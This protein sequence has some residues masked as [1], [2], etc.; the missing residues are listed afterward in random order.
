MKPVF[1]IA[2]LF[3]SAMAARCETVDSAEPADFVDSESSAESKCPP[4]VDHMDGSKINYY[5]VSGNVSDGMDVSIVL[6][7][8]R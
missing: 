7:S 2:L 1:I 6:Q 3:I 4:G 8:A 5:P